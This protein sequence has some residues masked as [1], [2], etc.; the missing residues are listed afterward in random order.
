MKTNFAAPGLLL[1]LT[2]GPFRMPGQTS[3]PAP[4]FDRA[5]SWKLIL[6][7]LAPI[8][9]RSGRS[10]HASEIFN[11]DGGPWRNRSAYSAG[12]SRCST[13]S[14]LYCFNGFNHV[15]TGNV[16]V[17]GTIAVPVALYATSF[18][19][20]DLKMRNT[21]LLAQRKQSATQKSWRRF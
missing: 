9:K 16:T 7:D 15:F 2:I 12:P 5:V 6:P 3:A 19:T 8:K 17:Y 18:A 21:A 1:V 14:E 10:R 11:T 20:K 13:V 4:D